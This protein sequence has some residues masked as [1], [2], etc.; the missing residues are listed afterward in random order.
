MGYIFPQY[1]L[2]L[3]FS[4]LSL[5]LNYRCLC[6]GK[7]IRVKRGRRK[8]SWGHSLLTKERFGGRGGVR[9]SGGG[10]ERLC[11]L[12]GPDERREEEGGGGGGEEESLTK[13]TIILV[14]S[15][16]S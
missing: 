13:G 11:R 7:G 14:T 5:C 4:S 10:G 15:D 9:G 12:Y 2:F 6:R 16:E 8:R 1:S 3:G